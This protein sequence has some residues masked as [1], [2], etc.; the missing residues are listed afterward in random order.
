MITPFCAWVLDRLVYNRQPRLNG[1]LAQLSGEWRAIADF[2]A[3]AQPEKRLDFWGAFLAGRPDRDDIIRAMADVKPSEP[4]PPID[5]SDPAD[6]WGPIRLGT[7][8]PVEPFPIDVLPLPARA[9]VEAAATAIS[10]PV[11]FPA[12]GILA[13]AS[14][15][16]GRSAC[17][18]VKPGYFAS[19]SLYVALVGSPST[20]KSPALHAALAPVRSIAEALDDQWQPEM[21]QWTAADPKTRG[22]EPALKRI[23]TT[24]PTTEALAPILARNPRGLI[25]C[26]DEMTRWV[27]SMDQYKGGKG[28][29]RPFYLSAWSGELVCVD[30]AKHAREPVVVPH[31]FLSVAGGLTPDMLTTLPEVRGRDDGFIARL[32][33]AYP[34]RIARHYSEQ[35]IPDGVA[36]EWRRVAMALWTRGMRDL[37]GK[38]APRVVKLSPEAARAWSA[39]CQAHYD[40]QEADDFPES[41]DGPWG[42]LE[43][44]AARLALILHLMVLTSDPIGPIPDDPP[45]LPTPTIEAAFRLV[46]YFR[47]QARRVY[48]A[49]GGKAEDR[50]ED[51][52]ALVRWILRNNL[53]EFSERDIGRNFDRFKDDPAALADALG[54]MAVHNLIR[55][56]EIPEATGK[57]GRK[58]SPRYD[59]NPTLRTSPRFRQF[60]RNALP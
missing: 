35:G 39:W 21:A 54:W 13:A 49:I 29:D 41:L 14:G 56:R 8:P 38:P 31:P 46:G 59:V 33:F 22:D 55:L 15:I 43:A 23:A 7:L 60:R 58:Q 36:V 2:R 51:V 28:G 16:I 24:D 19:A 30:R 53:N 4:A 40:E 25:L 34:D 44:Y 45:E 12:L 47:T 5:V 57:A 26:P 50:G 3:E 11:D 42:K 1:E 52:R 17:L 27:L 6:D 48:A 32:L 37:D 20:G 18:L 10:C 9:L